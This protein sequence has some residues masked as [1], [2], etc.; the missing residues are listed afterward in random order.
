MKTQI[1]T[2]KNTIARKTYQILFGRFMKVLQVRY[3]SYIYFKNENYLFNNKSKA[4]YEKT[5]LFS[6]NW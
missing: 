5:I 4:N 2:G 6:Q 3:C 1:D